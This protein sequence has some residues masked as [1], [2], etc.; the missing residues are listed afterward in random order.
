MYGNGRNC[1]ACIKQYIFFMQGFVLRMDSTPNLKQIRVY[2]LNWIE[3][4]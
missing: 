1:L 3:K 2:S 4:I